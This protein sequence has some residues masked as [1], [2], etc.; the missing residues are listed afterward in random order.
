M[1]VLQGNRLWTDMPA[2]EWISAVTPNIDNLRA[3]GLNNQPAH[4]LA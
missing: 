2:T 4:G 3:L 1:N